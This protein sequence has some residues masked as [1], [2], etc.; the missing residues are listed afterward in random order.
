[1]VKL[2]QNWSDNKF[3]DLRLGICQGYVFLFWGL[4]VVENRQLLFNGCRASIRKM[5]MFW[6]W[7]VVTVAQQCQY[8]S[9]YWTVYFKMIKMLTFKLGI[10]YHNF[11]NGQRIWASSSQK[12]KY[13]RPVN[14]EKE[15]KQWMRE[16][17]VYETAVSLMHIRLFGHK[18]TE[19]IIYHFCG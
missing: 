16:R 13:M 14:S 7:T 10:F 6:R 19:K 12:T 11:L 3:T 2:V 1:M 18:K 17:Y 4:G 9:Y 8:T 5:K 15:K